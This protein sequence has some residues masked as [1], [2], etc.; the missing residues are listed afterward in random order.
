MF[1]PC[2]SLPD[3]QR[4]HGLRASTTS[5]CPLPRRGGC[6]VGGGALYDISATHLTPRALSNH[7]L[8]VR[9]SEARF[10]FSFCCCVSSSATPRRPDAPVLQSWQHM[11]ARH[12]A[13]GLYVVAPSGLPHAAPRP[14]PQPGNSGT[15]RRVPANPVAHCIGSHAHFI[16]SQ[17]PLIGSQH[18]KGLRPEQ[19]LCFFFLPLWLTA[20]PI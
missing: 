9:S 14:P 7:S 15:I 4:S 2:Y 13:T 17:S 6:V 11:G 19:Q 5:S 10:C 3:I 1:Q 8:L 12:L 20:P 18:R 16:G